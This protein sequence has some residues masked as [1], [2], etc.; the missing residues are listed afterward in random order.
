MI[1]KVRSFIYEHALI[2]KSEK[3]LVALSGGMD[4][5][6]LLDVLYKLKDEIGFRLCAAHFD[7]MIRETSGSDAEFAKNLCNKLGIE[8]YM[9]KGDAPKCSADEKI[10]LESAARKLRHAYL[11]HAAAQAGADKIAFAHH[12]NDRAETY[13]MRALRGTGGDGLGCMPEM[14]GIIIR[15]LLCMQRDEIENYAEINRLSWRE[16]E[17]NSDTA[18]TRNRLRHETIPHLEK[19][20]NESVISTLANNARL[21][22]ADRDYFDSEVKKALKK[23]HQTD[24]GYY[25]DDDSFIYLHKAILT[26]CIRKTLSMLGFESDIYEINIAQVIELFD[27]QKTGAMINLPG[28]AIARRDAFGV[29]IIRGDTAPEPFCET[30]IDLSGVTFVPGCGTFK[31]EHCEID[32][33]KIKNHSKNVA[34]F[35]TMSL[36]G[37]FVVRSRREGDVFHALGSPGSKSLKKYFID[38]KISRFKRDYIPLVAQE[39]KIVWIAGHEIGDDYKVTDESFSAVKITFHRET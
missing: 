5:V 21:M 32:I 28:G 29:E 12:K 3:I 9:S 31:C 2:N 11:R 22:A 35:D 19:Y 14:D 39:N 8:I 6:V 36:N 37:K 1:D 33:K 30:P 23:A 24:D 34:F 4:S 27:E 7:H 18:Y 15:P 26:R 25:L 20:Y 38:K 10:S 13:L 16:D 17:T